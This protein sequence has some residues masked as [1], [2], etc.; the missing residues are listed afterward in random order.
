MQFITPTLL[1]DESTSSVLDF[2]AEHL[3]EFVTNVARISMY[4]LEFLSV[5]IIV[6]TTIVAFYKLIRKDPIARVYLL[7]GQSLGLSFK[8]GSEILRTVT[9]RNIDDIWEV[10]LLIV[11]K[12]FMVLLIDWELKGTT[13]DSSSPLSELSKGK[14]MA[15]KI[16]APFAKEH[17]SGK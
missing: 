15:A 3:H 8:L 16:K 10:L 12:A 6:F 7:H 2:I 4:S 13:E 9:A 11:I 1:L 14:A 17:S 5:L